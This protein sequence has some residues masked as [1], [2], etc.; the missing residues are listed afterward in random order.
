MNKEDVREV[1]A[2]CLLQAQPMREP[3]VRALVQETVRE[4]LTALGVDQSN[5]LEVQRDL[6]WLRDLR[7]ASASARAKAGAAVIGILLTAAAVAV[8]A[9]VKTMLRSPD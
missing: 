3:E 9:G 5:P 1:V 8:W 7:Q 6:L 4:T 2:E